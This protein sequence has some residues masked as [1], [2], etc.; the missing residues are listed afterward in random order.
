M[1][2]PLSAKAARVI[3]VTSITFK[4]YSASEPSVNGFLSSGTLAKRIFFESKPSELAIITPPLTK[5]FK[6][7][8]KAATFITTNTS[9]MSP[10][11]LILVEPKCI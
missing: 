6:F 5:P 8:F 1:P 11:V 9:L 10:G 2:K 3:L 4:S 7:A